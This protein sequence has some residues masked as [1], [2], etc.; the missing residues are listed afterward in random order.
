VPGPSP[1]G[2]SR[3]PAASG[4]VLFVSYSGVFGGAE[5]SLVDIAA[6]LEQPAVLLCAHGPLASRA[7]AARLPTLVR[8]ARAPE[9]RGNAGTRV[10]AAL[11]LAGHAREVGTVVAALRP[12]AV[13]ALGMRSAIACAAAL[14]LRRRQPPLII[15]HVDFLPS[16][17]VALA[18]RAAA[19]RAE[20]VVAPSEAVAAD[21]DPRGRLGDS[22]TVAPPGIDV[23]SFTPSTPADTPVALTL[24]AIVPWK[25]PDL[26]LEAVAAAAARLDG[27]R[28]VLAGHTVGE[29]SG[30]LLVALR[31]RAREPDLAGRVEL[32][33]PL[34][35]PREA[36][37]RCSCLLHCAEREPFGL[38]LLEA[39]A[40][41]RPVV[42]P[43][44]GGP[45]EIVGE[46]C[47]RLYAPGDARAAAAALVELLGDREQLRRAGKRAR[48]HVIERFALGP[49]R[50]R[51]LEAAGPAVAAMAR[52]PDAGRGLTLVT[53]THDSEDELG[54]L[55]RSVARH[56]PGA[57]VVVADSGSRDGSVAVAKRWGG[58]AA[59]VELGDAGYGRAANAGVTRVGTPACVVLNPDVELVDD[60]LA[61]LVAEALRSDAPE[62][63][64]APLVLRPDGTRQDSVHP[65]PLSAATVIA[66]LVPPAALPPPL[67]KA[68]QPWRR[69]RPRAVAWAVGCSLGARTETLRR[70]G[71]FEERIFLYGEDLELG[72]RAREQGIAT[73]WWPYARVVHHEAHA[74]RRTFAGEP[75]ELL[76]RQRHAVLATRRGEPAARWDDRL[77]AA[78]FANRIALKALLGR[79]NGRERRQLKAVRL[80]GGTR[81]ARRTVTPIAGRTPE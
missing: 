45:L 35:D 22:L 71:P 28:L 14:A 72:L 40:S 20:R 67:R 62:R 64:L 60:S 52:R 6:G 54:R 19:A 48:G 17:G 18:F 73:W 50:R 53:V 21:L 55:L 70:L 76:A 26:A 30:R 34:D 68:V 37:A 38:V 16:P 33:G 41:G 8:P 57:A 69:D 39:M 5:R 63:L 11:R 1:Q 27:L 61:A 13:V 7:S 74:A 36:L 24:G 49:A 44:A 66:A 47:G 77:Q 9:L 75:F 23:E 56:L 32:A 80:T 2:S 42:A 31:R 43:R 15:Q 25:R 3:A 51:W 81:L 65:E 58:R 59:V 12:R 29:E 46:G 78:T 10:H 4:P 79:S